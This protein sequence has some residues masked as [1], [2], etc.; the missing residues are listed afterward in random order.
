[1]TNDKAKEATTCEDTELQLVEKETAP[2]NEERI[3]TLLAKTD[4]IIAKCKNRKKK[5]KTA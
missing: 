2:T 3:K 4:V 1:M 5:R